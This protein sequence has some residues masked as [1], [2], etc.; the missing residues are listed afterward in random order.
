MNFEDKFLTFDLWQNWEGGCWA[1]KRENR[2]SKGS[3]LKDGRKK[4]AQW[5]SNFF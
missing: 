5:Y 1:T 4:M 2:T 3:Q